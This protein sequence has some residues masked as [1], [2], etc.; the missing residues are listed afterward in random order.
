[1]ADYFTSDHFK[2]L[3]KW[4]DGKYEEEGDWTPISDH[5]INAQ[6]NCMECHGGGVPQAPMA[7]R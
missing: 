7:K 4:K 1:M 6:P 3:N 5:G 2:L